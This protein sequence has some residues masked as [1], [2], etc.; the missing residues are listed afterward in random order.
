MRDRDEDISELLTMADLFVELGRFFLVSF[1]VL[2][3][4]V[5]IG[6]ICG[7]I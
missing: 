5:I 2:G 4:G 1:S 6:L 7:A 3:T